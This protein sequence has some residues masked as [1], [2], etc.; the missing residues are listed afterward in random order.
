MHSSPLSRY[1]PQ[2]DD[3]M[4]YFLNTARQLTEY[5][6]TAGALSGMPVMV[7]GLSHIHKAHFLAAMAQETEHKFPVI[8]ICDT[9]GE[10][11]RLCA[12]INTMTGEESAFSFPAK[13][14]VLGDVD[15]VS[16][17]Y[18]HRRIGILSRMLSGRA[19]IVCA[20]PEAASQIT[21]PR[22]ILKKRT[23]TI[24]TGDRISLPDITSALVEAGYSRCDQIEGVSQFSV[25][26]AILDVYPVNFGAPVRI[27][28]WGDD[29]DSISVFDI[30][31]QRRIDTIKK[32]DIAPALETL[33]LDNEQIRSKLE[34][35]L[36][37]IRGKKERKFFPGI[38]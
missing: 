9:E 20:T 16:R 23:V 25:R 10:G 36:P 22:K 5:R 4:E 8:A 37:K 12:D 1:S 18:E 31:S 32:I 6:S 14:I 35:L 38:L 24:N 15:A 34:A 11:A 28:L 30:E 3:L 26:G 7:T 13:D 2:K 27:E 19:K 33:F 21:I 29:V 17:E